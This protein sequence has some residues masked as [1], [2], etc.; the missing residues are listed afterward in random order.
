MVGVS[1]FWAGPIHSRFTRA[2]ATDRP[3]LRTLLRISA[4]RSLLMLAASALVC[5]SMARALASIG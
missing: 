3:G 5:W 2:G 4:L 1:A